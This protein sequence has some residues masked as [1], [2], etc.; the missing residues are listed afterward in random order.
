[1]VL[2]YTLPSYQHS[3]TYDVH[4]AVQTYLTNNPSV[5]L[6]D[7]VYSVSFG[8]T[9]AAGNTNS[10][11]GTLIIYGSDAPV[12]T[13]HTQNG[14]SANGY[15]YASASNGTVYFTET[16]ITGLGTATGHAQATSITTP[17]TVVGP[18]VIAF[19]SPTANTYTLGGLGITTQDGYNLNSY[20]SNAYNSDSANSQTSATQKV[21]YDT[22]GPNAPTFAATNANTSTSTSSVAYFSALPTVTIS[23]TDP[24]LTA[25][26]LGSGVKSIYY[27]LSTSSTAPSTALPGSWTLGSTFNPSSLSAGTYYL[28]AVAVD[29][30][31]NIGAIGTLEV[32]YDPATPT[33][34]LY[35]NGSLMSTTVI[36]YVSAVQSATLSTTDTDVSSLSFKVDN[37]S[38]TTYSALDTTLKDELSPAGSHT[39]KYG[40]TSNAGLTDEWNTATVVVST[41]APTTSLTVSGSVYNNGI[42]WVKSTPTVTITGVD[43]SGA[44]VT[45][46]YTVDGIISG[47]LASPANINSVTSINALLSTVGTHTVSFYGTSAGG[48]E[49]P[50]HTATIT[51]DVTAPT[52][53]VSALTINGSSAINVTLAD[54]GSGINVAA[55]YYTIDGGA[56]QSFTSTSP[57]SGARP[58]LQYYPSSVTATSSTSKAAHTVTVYAVDALGNSN[59]TTTSLSASIWSTPILTSLSPNSAN[60]GSAATKITAYGYNFIKGA[61]IYWGNSSLTTTFVDSGTL[62]ATLSKTQLQKAGSVSVT[63]KSSGFL[64]NALP[65]TLN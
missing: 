38:K 30:V 17:S 4:A 32:V 24:A 48:T 9:D 16:D 35:V 14:Y 36:N 5:T 8:C 33:T 20:A 12:T 61:V 34:S 46:H 45:I 28:Y 49:T 55:S 41:T 59:T 27:Q 1:M 25:S 43:T 53:S 64:S 18:T 2:S 65:F 39:V 22:T 11:T 44:P 19:G 29:N 60:H 7:G 62:T 13:I 54:A 31:G 57:K 3:Y 50:V 23:A 63:V 42:Y 10:N 15:W 51:Y 58:S 56:Q 26:V 37:G 6:S 47:S 21:A 40:A 52:A